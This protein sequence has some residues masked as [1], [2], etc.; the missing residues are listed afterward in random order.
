MSLWSLGNLD[1]NF[2]QFSLHY[3]DET[4]NRLIVKK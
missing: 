2:S 1:E 3:I 4:G